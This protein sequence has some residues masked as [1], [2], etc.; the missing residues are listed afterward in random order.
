MP[1]GLAWAAKPAT[2]QTD[3]HEY[4]HPWK[5]KMTARRRR[6]PRGP[7]SP[8]AIEN[9]EQQLLDNCREIRRKPQPKFVVVKLLTL[10]LKKTSAQTH[11]CPPPPP[12]AQAHTNPDITQKAE[13]QRARTPAAPSTSNVSSISIMT[14]QFDIV[15]LTDLHVGTN[16]EL[17][18]TNI[19]SYFATARAKCEILRKNVLTQMHIKIFIVL[20]E[21]VN[22]AAPTKKHGIDI[23]NGACLTRTSGTGPPV[24]T[25]YPACVAA[26]AAMSAR[27][28]AKRIPTMWTQ[29]SKH[30]RRQPIR[31]HSRWVGVT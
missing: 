27:S 5:S 20:V 2:V 18:V 24:G 10:P 22:V 13:T 30:R 11:T 12:R 26:R 3:P 21:M 19:H 1:S 16:V 28:S 17:I 29:K 15:G 6:A 31:H 4:E 8:R 14:H 25:S 7:P 9:M 23:A